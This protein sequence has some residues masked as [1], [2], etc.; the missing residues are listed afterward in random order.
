MVARLLALAVLLGTLAACESAAPTTS[1]PAAALV[2]G[3]VIRGGFVAAGP[4]MPLRAPVAVAASG[5]DLYVADAGAG[6]LLRIDPIAGRV[7]TIAS[8]RA[9]PGMRL[10]ADIDATLYA[11]DPVTRRILRFGRDGRALQAFTA[12]ATVASLRALALDPARGRLLGLDALNRQLVA[13]R[14]LGAYEVI[15]LRFEPRYAIQSLDALAVGRDALYA[16]DARCACLVRLDFEGRVVST[17]GHG[18]LSQPERLAADRGGRLY[19]YDRGERALKVFQEA[20]LVETLALA[21]LG[22][23]EVS[24]LAYADG[25]LYVADAAGAQVRMFR[26]QPAPKGGR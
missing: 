22:L 18:S 9:L 7:V 21:R 6:T 2:P 13:F 25:W 1:E 17:F 4:F 3:P 10:A 24:D 16:I 19:V 15:A 20:Q 26:V 12:D 14:P 23:S 5:P 8:V 11:L